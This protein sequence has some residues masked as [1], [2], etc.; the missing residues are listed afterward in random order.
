MRTLRIVKVATI[1]A[2]A[3]LVSGAVVAITAAAAGLPAGL[4]AAASPSPKPS[5][6]PNGSM[7]AYCQTYINNLAS[8]LGKKPSD[9]QSAAQKALGQ[10]LDQ[11]VKDGKLTQAQADQIKKRDAAGNVC[12]G[13]RLGPMGAGKA[14]AGLGMAGA[15]ALYLPDAAKV[16]GM[17]PADLMTALRGGQ[18]LSQIAAS[19]NMNEQQFR[20]ALTA[21]VKTDLDAQVKSGKLTQAQEDSI[22]N[23]LKTDPLPMWN[24]AAPA[25]GGRPGHPSASPSPTGS[26]S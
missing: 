20:D 10:T 4:V 8:D 5:G 26:T 18:T 2:G 13:F 22:L 3:L 6:P 24:S 7:Q 25:R 17:S 1:A 23:H 21:Q 15:G 14:N 16:L 11:A 12:D 9:V 19:K